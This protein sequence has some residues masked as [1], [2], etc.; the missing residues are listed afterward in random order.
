MKRATVV[1]IAAVAAVGLFLWIR[2]RPQVSAATVANPP[3]A[4][5][6]AAQAALA[7]QN[8]VTAG[9][10]WSAQYLI[11]RI[12]PSKPA[13]A[14]ETVPVPLNQKMPSGT[15]TVSTTNL[16]TTPFYA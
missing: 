13:N 3:P 14:V 6:P 7:F 10:N 11:D 5:S 2:R 12:W 15:N 8:L 9:S 16:V 1:L 4:L